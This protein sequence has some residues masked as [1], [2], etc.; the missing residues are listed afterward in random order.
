MVA[1]LLCSVATFPMTTGFM[2]SRN[3]F[4]LKLPHTPA[5]PEMP[6]R[7]QQDESQQDEGE[8]EAEEEEHVES[9][10]RR[11]SIDSET[12]DAVAESNETD[13]EPNASV[14]NDLQT[15]PTGQDDGKIT[16]NQS[17]GS[18][19]Q[20]N[21]TRQTLLNDGDVQYTV[22]MSIGGQMMQAILDTGSFDVLVFSQHCWLCGDVESLYDDKV[23]KTYK[24]GGGLVIEHNFGSGS[25]ESIAAFEELQFGELEDTKQAFW[26]V[27]DAYMP[28]LA[29]SSFQSIVGLG[30]PTSSIKMAQKDLE[31]MQAEIS[32]VTESGKKISEKMEKQAK[33]FEKVVEFTQEQRSLVESLDAMTFSICLSPEALAPGIFIWRDDAPDQ[34]PDAFVTVPVVG[35][36][37][38]SAEMTDVQLGGSEQLSLGCASTASGDQTCSAV[39]DTGTSLIV[40][41][42]DAAS[43]VHAAVK[44]WGGD[45]DNLD[46]LPAL[47][48][49]LGGQPFS[50]PPASYVGKVCG[51][52]EDLD[53]D[54]RR[55]LAHM[56]KSLSGDDDCICAAMVMS[57]DVPTENGP[58]WVLG[59]P[60]FRKYYTSFQLGI[61]STADGETDARPYAKSMSFSLADEKCRPTLLNSPQATDAVLLRGPSKS[62][63]VDV[64]K[65]LAPRFV[66]D[67]ND[68]VALASRKFGR[69]AAERNRLVENAG[70]QAALPVNRLRLRALPEQN[71]QRVIPYHARGQTPF[72]P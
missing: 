69:E 35:D 33:H 49:T 5:M 6:G 8:A 28:I 27:F 45:C 61:N 16:E 10:R 68:A 22:N 67:S 36:L 46:A 9:S 30:P 2:I 70:R 31:D 39:L 60:F 24:R 19:E 3:P 25:T 32:N 72:V 48:F 1:F 14:D 51:S 59:I 26:E 63:T 37:Y 58:M 53:D 34:W 47:E 29:E 66:R 64:T 55:L 62:I 13:E 57:E 65:V 43:K 54:M 17:N 42:K 20:I 18:Y 40:A 15:L 44:K 11:D 52:F 56:N 4:H 38:W 23:S 7:H 41:P 71:S 50:L 21:G 12:T